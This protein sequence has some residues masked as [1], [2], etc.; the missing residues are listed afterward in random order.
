[1]LS[2]ILVAILG[3]PILIYIFY[4]GGFP[5]LV[6]SNV[7]IGIGLYE[8]YKMSEEIGNKPYLKTGILTGLLFPNFI[9][10]SNFLENKI[11]LFSP[12]IFIFIL[13][14][15]MR[16]GKSQIENTSRDVGITLLGIFYISV[17][18]SHI[19][20]LEKL[21]NGGKLILLIQISVW[22]C[23]SAAY[24]V[25]M[26]FGR[27]FF[28]EGLSKISP[29]KSK[30][31]TIGGILFTTITVIILNSLFNIL[32][33]NIILILFLGLII[34]ITAQIG[35]LAES[36]F[37]REFKIKDSGKLLGEHGGILDRFDSMIFVLPVVYNLL[38][39][40]IY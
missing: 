3:I 7:I 38:K 8:F 11:N 5:L 15:I 6:F 10:F 1:M 35:D 37:K 39:I 24:F 4:V 33:V 16:M 32:D 28:K 13:I 20:L 29:K 17:L 34:S 14:M 19:L 27:K 31:G 30:E 2:R 25:G 22:V 40:F 9:Y 36:M 21:P 18:F 26:K 23:D 12:L